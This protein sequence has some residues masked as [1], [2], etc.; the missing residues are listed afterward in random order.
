[1][2]RIKTQDHD[3]AANKGEFDMEAASL[4]KLSQSFQ[5]I[6]NLVLCENRHIAILLTS[7]VFSVIQIINY[8]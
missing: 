2:P 8:Q 1:L 6:Q 5:A 4:G 7:S 3:G